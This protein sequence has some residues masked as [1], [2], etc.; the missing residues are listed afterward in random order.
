M[1]YKLFLQDDATASFDCYQRDYIHDRDVSLTRWSRDG[2][3]C[4]ADKITEQSRVLTFT[5]PIK[6]TML[7]GPSE[8]RT[9]RKQKLR[10]FQHCGITLENDTAV[11]GI[12]AAD[13]FSVRDF[14]RIEADGTDHVILSV[15]FAPNFTKRTIFKNIIE[16]S[17]VKETSVWFSGYIAMMQETL[18]EG[19]ETLPDPNTD[20]SLTRQ[21]ETGDSER[22][23]QKLLHFLG[24]M[25]LFIFALVLAVNGYQL[26]L[27][28]S[29]VSDI[30]DEM[31]A[32]RHLTAQMQFGQEIIRQ[33]RL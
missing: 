18:Q 29:A 2:H 23:Q 28:Y 26:Y 11:E 15:N 13:T 32:L 12:P 6:N 22:H 3:L 30:K 21:I 9:T 19:I 25:M 20:G 7:M 5:H 14:W 17:V 4:D 31:V 33:C 27:I 24:F 10:R 1:F 16:K 8:A